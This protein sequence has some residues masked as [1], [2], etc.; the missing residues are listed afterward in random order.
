MNVKGM[1]L[2]EFKNGSV[3][4]EKGSGTSLYEFTRDPYPKP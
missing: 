3:R 1:S 4:I 2:Y